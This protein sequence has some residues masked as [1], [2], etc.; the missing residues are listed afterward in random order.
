MPT[1]F[2][3]GSFGRSCM[4]SLLMV[5]LLGAPIV[6]LEESES[7]RQSSFSGSTSADPLG[8]EAE[9]WQCS[10]TMMTSTMSLEIAPD[11]N[12]TLLED[13]SQFLEGKEGDGT[14]TVIWGAS[15]CLAKYLHA[16][17]TLNDSWKVIELGCGVGL[18]TLVVAKMCQKSCKERLFATDSEEATLQQLKAV[19]ELNNLQGKLTATKFDWN[20]HEESRIDDCVTVGV[21]VLLASDVIYSR[22]MVAPLVQGIRRILSPGRKNMKSIAYLAFKKS[23]PGVK[24]F[25]EEALPKA[26]FEL[27]ETVS[28]QEYLHLDDDSPSRWE[29][30][31]HSVYVFT[32]QT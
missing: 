11:F 10:A 32:S 29:G 17:V 4:L 7:K 14:G 16:H 25:V 31:D 24:Y 6:S 3:F 22:S 18:P 21:D 1:K 26:G 23:R 28:C 30:D 19:V 8:N 20:S 2:A 27:I 13:A 9:N 15:I 5:T 12:L